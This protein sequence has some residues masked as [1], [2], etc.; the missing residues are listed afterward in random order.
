[1]AKMIKTAKC[2]SVLGSY[3]T[4]KSARSDLNAVSK[5]DVRERRLN[6]ACGAGAV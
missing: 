4:R 1:M 6:Q 3:G 2:R 5:G